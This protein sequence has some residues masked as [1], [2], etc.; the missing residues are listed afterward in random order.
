MD[1]VTQLLLGAAVGEA[2][3]GR[4]VGRRAMA[5]GAACGTLPDLDVFA[6]YADAVAAFT[7][8]RS[9]SHSLLV[10]AA[11]T[12]LVVWLILKLHPQTRRHRRGWVT[13]V[14]LAFATHVLLDSFTVYGTQIFWPVLTTPMT[15]SSIFIID[16][17]YTIPLLV[18]VLGALVLSRQRPGGRRLNTAGLAISTLYL[19]WSIGA[20]V[21]VH[22]QAEAALVSRDI[23]PERVLITPAPFTTVLW[24]ILVMAPDGYYEGYYS[25]LDGERQIHFTRHV[26]ERQWLSGIEDYGPVRRLQWFTKGFYGV[27]RLGDDVLITDLRMGLE[28]H[29]VFRFRVGEVR[30]PHSVRAPVGRVP[31][32]RGYDRLRWLWQRIW[33]A[34]AA[35]LSEA[36]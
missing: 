6:P 1:S 20:K 14:Y 9:F 15:W 27:S 31:S 36:A 17:L 2:T 34:N 5:W 19:A 12:P 3:L 4:R 13:L 25:L 10:L 23:A 35:R 32:P 28:P 11:L 18:G 29:Y 22:E 8:H 30:N 33:D 7:Y 16:P 21:Y 26:S 24:R